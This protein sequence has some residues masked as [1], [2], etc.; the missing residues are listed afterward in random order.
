MA[1]T[2]NIFNTDPYYDDYDAQKGF[3]RILFKPGYALQAR[4]LTQAQTILQNQLSKIAD[5]LFKDGSRVIGGGLSVRN[6]SFVMLSV[7]GDSPLRG[8]DDYTFMVGG[9]ISSQGSQISAKIIHVLPPDTTDGNLVVFVDFLSG[10]EFSQQQNISFEK[11]DA[12]AINSISVASS[13][14]GYPTQGQCKV[15]SVSDGVFYVNGF[16]VAVFASSFVPYRIVNN[17]R[18]FS[19]VSQNVPFAALSKKIGFSI[20]G[21]GVVTDEQDSTLRDPSIGSYNYNAPGADRYSITLQLSQY[22]LDESP[23]SFVELLKFDGGKITKKID[24]VSYAEIQKELARRTYDESGSY[25]VSPF[26]ITVKNGNTDEDLSVVFGKGKAYVFGYEVDNEYPKTVQIQKAR[27]V[28]EEANTTY[29]FGIGNSI[30]ATLSTAQ[31]GYV[32]AL[33]TVSS[34]STKIVFRK[35]ST[36]AEGYVHGIVPVIDGAGRTANTYDLYLYGL[37]GSLNPSVALSPTIANIYNIATGATL[38][39]VSP[40]STPL[41][42]TNYPV[43]DTENASLVYRLSTGYAVNNISYLKILGLVASEQTISPITNG[44][45]TTYTFNKTT[46]SPAFS[47]SNASVFSFLPYGQATTNSVDVSK[48]Y[49]VN[50]GGVAYSPSS[51]TLSNNNQTVSLVV[52][53][54]PAGFTVGTAQLKV[55]APVVY[56]PVIDDPNTYRTKTATDFTITVS[57]S[58]SSIR[59]DENGRKYFA[60]LDG[61]TPQYDV[62][63]VVSVDTVGTDSITITEDFELDDGQRDTHY[64]VARLYIKREKENLPRYTSSSV[65]FTIAARKFVHGGLLSAPFIGKHSYINTPYEQIPVY[66]DKKTGQSMS[67]ANC[68]DFRKTGLE[69]TT[70]MMKPYGR[71]QFGIAGDTVVTYNHY[72][73][74]IDKLCVKSDPDDGSALFFSVSGTPDLAP[75]APPDPQDAIVLANLTVQAYTHD[76]NSVYITPV[77]SRRYTMSD[78][79]KMEKR[80]DDV[81][82]FAKLSL[83]EQEIEARSLKASAI[84]VEPLKTSIFVDEFYGHSVGDVADSE[85]SCSIDYERGELRP[86]FSTTPVS[87]PDASL[88]GTVQ[89]VDGLVTLIHTE[90][91]YINNK[92]FTT[93]IKPNS[94]GSVNWLGFMKLNPSV[95]PYYDQFYRPVVKSNS[96]MENDNWLGSNTSGLRGFG[97]QWN[98]W[99]SNWTGILENEEEQDDIQ[100]RLVEFPRS[101]SDSTIPSLSSG[102]SKFGINR[103]VDSVTKSTSNFIR[104][105]RLKNRIKKKVSGRLVDRTVVPYMRERSVSGTVWGLKPNVNNLVVYFD[106]VPVVSQISTDSTGSCSF[107]FSIPANTHL[108]GDKLVRISDSAVVENCTVSAEAVYHC[109]GVIEQRESGVFSTRPSELRRQYV[110]SETFSKDPFNRDIDSIGSTEWSDPLSQTFFVDKKSNPNGIFLKSVSLY[111]AEKDADLPIT[112]QIRPTVSGYPSPSVVV[113]FSTVGKNAEDVNANTNTPTET[114]FEFSSPV[115]LEPGEYAICVLTNSSNYSMFA[116]SSSQNT[117]AVGSAVGGRAG[118]NQNVGTLFYPQGIGPSAPDNALDLMFAVSRCE[119]S[120]GT[121]YIQWGSTE[122]ESQVENVAN[123]QIVKVYA[124]EIL[125]EPCVLERKMLL[126]NGTRTFENNESVYFT[127]TPT[128]A[129]VVVYSMRCGSDTSVS[130]VVDL[131]TLYFASVQ[132]NAGAFGTTTKYISRVIGLPTAFASNG[133]AVFLDANTPFNYQQNP[134]RVYYRG[135]REGESNI[136]SKQWTE[137]TRQTPQFA[138]SSELDYREIQ[139]RPNVP[140]AS[141]FVSYQIKVE[142]DSPSVTS[143]YKDTPSIRNIK[144]ISYIV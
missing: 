75:I 4:E 138:S 117:F 53:S 49:L 136:F 12:P 106:G 104:A 19:F 41:G 44:L 118:N 88:S 18:D 52:N 122:S 29:P 124:S 11:E 71:S 80:I 139:F 47:S 121:G 54:A 27:T 2:S 63:S 128:A 120:T 86:F 123:R 13:S 87:L 40:I 26:D 113:P 60:I 96:L 17:A 85:Y 33:H 55:I 23:E 79:G 90:K 127:S 78:I 8:L 116:V 32:G 51:G 67:L 7:E 56:T 144:T 61:T 77:D 82:V 130:P 50:S 73:P 108:V 134:V 58:V 22:E 39:D 84:S 140:F 48:I 98:D 6:A 119:F 92:Q 95:D 65:S 64:D 125:P 5:H 126:S 57:S 83:S 31:T 100:K 1:T 93:T 30:R 105:R 76:K 24:R 97:T 25:T 10:E 14:A 66:V 141:T 46:F 28:Q 107:T 35:G 132:M 131:N 69:S 114:K 99:E 70:A 15:V 142:M 3:L 45:Q 94:S 110:N 74:R 102:N 109:G 9:K 62:Y 103:T 72:L 16:F 115:Y 133:I 135:L 36:V 111:F 129:P 34:G 91:E 112:I 68:L 137:I 21:D 81:E 59:T 42:S 20:Q 38:A 101:V 89:S 43:S 37:S 143:P